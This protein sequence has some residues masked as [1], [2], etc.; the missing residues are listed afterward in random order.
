MKSSNPTIPR[1][2]VLVIAALPPAGGRGESSTAGNY[3]WRIMRPSGVTCTRSPTRNARLSTTRVWSDPSSIRSVMRYGPEAAE[4]LVPPADAEALAWDA[5][6]MVWIT[7]EVAF[8]LALTTGT[9]P[10]VATGVVG[11]GS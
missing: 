8:E 10:V 2:S 3:C 11:G 4:A 7:P 5:R 6:L 1:A 9:P